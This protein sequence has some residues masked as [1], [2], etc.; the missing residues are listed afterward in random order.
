MTRAGVGVLALAAVLASAPAAVAQDAVPTVAVAPAAS[1]PAA[2][3][4]A[5]PVK[6]RHARGDPLEGFNRAMFSVNQVFDRVL[7]RPLAKAYEKIVPK[8]VR[9]G[10]RHFFSNLQ[11][12]VVFV[13]DV[14]QLKPKR[15][16]R[17]LGRF[18]VNSTVGIG[19]VLDVAKTQDFRL[20]HRD[21]GFGNTLGRY[22]LGPGPY[23]YLP[24][25]GPSDFRDFAGGQ[26]D[27][28]ALRFGIGTPFDR[29]E[30][31]AP[32]AV[33]TGLDLRA[34]ADGALV[35][36]LGGAVDPYATLRSA[37]LQ[38]RAGTVEELRHGTRP[39]TS[40]LDD[41]LTDPA[42]GPGAGPVPT[43]SPLDDP[44]TDPGAV[45]PTSAIVPQT[46]PPPPVPILATPRASV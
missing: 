35:A 12:P 6:R 2:P 13:N 26:A 20:P 31:V 7:F 11:E 39:T 30:F 24:L 17:T 15:A 44:L 16:I 19:G 9:K 45:A 10:L 4:D 27:G 32:R 23:L 46:T 37:Y 38:D 41:P 22:G 3:V 43:A 42:A 34:E 14:L 8:L 18:T 36:L 33:I 5:P 25:F 40:P 29:A 28:Y 1:L 21:N